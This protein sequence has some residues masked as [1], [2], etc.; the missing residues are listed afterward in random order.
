VLVVD[1]NEDG[2]STIATLLAMWGYVAEVAHDGPSALRL[3]E[4]VAFDI[5]V[6]DIGLPVMDGYELA[7]RLRRLPGGQQMRLI[8]LTGYGQSADR[9][10]SF[11]SGFD[12]HLVKP[13]DVTT[14]AT[15]LD[16]LPVSRRQR[17]D[18]QD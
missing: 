1:D 7:G 11:E 9:K 3:V 12:V 15:T 14:L 4:H 18:L 16:A 2:A 8:A 10:R 6:L 17:S 5:G 13:I